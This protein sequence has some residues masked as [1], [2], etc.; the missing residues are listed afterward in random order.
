MVLI[1]V[2]APGI[3][4]GKA[5]E[6]REAILR[7]RQSGKEAWAYAPVLDEIDQMLQAGMAGQL[8]AHCGVHA[9][10]LGTAPVAR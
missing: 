9:F 7:Y 2:D 6:L 8:L 5:T 10:D 3:G 1:D 4:W